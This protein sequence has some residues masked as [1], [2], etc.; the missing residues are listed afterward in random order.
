MSQKIDIKSTSGKY[1]I[2]NGKKYL[3][4]YEAKQEFSLITVENKFKKEDV[5]FEAIKF[6]DITINGSIPNTISDAVDLLNEI[7]SSAESLTNAELRASA[8]PVL[9]S[10]ANGGN[11]AVTT[12]TT[13]TNYAAFASQVCKQ[14]TIANDSGSTIEFIQGG[15][16][17]AYPILDGTYY[18][19]F[20]ITNANQISIRR[21]D[22]S[23]T[24]VIIAAR[25]EA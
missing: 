16:G 5:L 3:K 13:G 10:M 9:P 14:L 22:V 20:G 6:N 18:T 25:W 19:V 15:A 2:L 7:V 17:A 21:K 23:N 11:L 8:L 1:F 12:N 24:T 4:N